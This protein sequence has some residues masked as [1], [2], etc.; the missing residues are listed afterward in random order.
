[1]KNPSNKERL[2]AL[3][4]SELKNEGCYLIICDGDAD[5]VIVKTG[6]SLASKSTVTIIGEDADLLALLLHHAKDSNF[7]LCFR[8]DKA[9]K[10]NIMP[11]TFDIG[12]YREILGGG[13][14]DE[15]ATLFSTS[16]RILDVIAH[17]RFQR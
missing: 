6:I 5:L 11:R 14:G 4:S 8:S 17:Q 2:I 3:I 9:S 13:G 1:M 15:Y 12:L 7:K 16:M 10:K